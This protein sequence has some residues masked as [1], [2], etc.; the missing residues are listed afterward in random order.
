MKDHHTQSRQEWLR[1]LQ[2]DQRAESAWWW[3]VGTVSIVA[4][5]W[6]AAILAPAIF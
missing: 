1:E 3:V 4:W 2:K 5:F 6:I